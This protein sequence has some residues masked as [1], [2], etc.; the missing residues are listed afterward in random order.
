MA[1]ALTLKAKESVYYDSFENDADDS[2]NKVSYTIEN[3]SQVVNADDG[4]TLQEVYDALVNMLNG[5]L[6]LVREVLSYS[7]IMVDCG[8]HIA[9]ES[10]LSK[11]DIYKMINN[12]KSQSTS[13]D[14]IQSLPDIQKDNAELRRSKRQ[15]RRRR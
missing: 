15:S 12:L 8:V 2:K 14:V 5:D 6:S 1:D 4:L 9:Q 10:Q 7:K 11:H 13:I 3:G